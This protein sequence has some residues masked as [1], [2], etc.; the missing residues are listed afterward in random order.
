KY[1]GRKKLSIK[2][3]KTSNNSSSSYSSNVVI[4]LLLF[5]LSFTTTTF[6]SKLLQQHLVSTKLKYNTLRNTQVY[7]NIQSRHLLT[8]KI[9]KLII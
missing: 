3:S 1:K 9:L 7:K 4:L 2:A 6:S 5:F 8:H